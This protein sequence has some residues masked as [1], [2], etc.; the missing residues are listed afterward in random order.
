MRELGEGQHK[1]SL[2]LCVPSRARDIHKMKHKKKLYI[3]IKI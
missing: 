3:L 2:Y 1:H